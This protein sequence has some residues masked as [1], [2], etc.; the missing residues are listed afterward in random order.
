MKCGAFTQWS[1][2]QLRKGKNPKLYATMWMNLTNYK[3]NKRSQTLKSTCYKI[4]S[5]KCLK[6]S[7]ITQ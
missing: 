5:T 6:T 4:P 1:I 2:I 3:G 7:K